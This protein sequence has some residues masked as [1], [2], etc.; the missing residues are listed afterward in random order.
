VRLTIK[1]LF[2]I[3]VLSIF[4]LGCFS[5]KCI[6][7]K[8]GKLMGHHYVPVLLDSLISFPEK[9]NGLNI[10]TTGYFIARFEDIAVYR[11]KTDCNIGN[12]RNA[13]WI[14]FNQKL[15]ISFSTNYQGLNAKYVKFRGTFNYA[16]KGHLNQYAGEFENV[17][18]MIDC[19]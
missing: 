16:K 13:F 12:K 2:F 17:Y 6:V 14:D 18:Y 4:L 19:L 3:G 15:E 7:A 1:F 9:Y 10:E 8:V 11:S 5:E